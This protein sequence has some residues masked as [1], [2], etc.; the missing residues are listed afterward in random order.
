MCPLDQHCQHFSRM[1]AVDIAGMTTQF[2]LE[3]SPVTDAVGGVY[4]CTVGG[5]SAGSTTVTVTGINSHFY[6]LN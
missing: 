4:T 1:D 6:S 2:G 3:I 5:G